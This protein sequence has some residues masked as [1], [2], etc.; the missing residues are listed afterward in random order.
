MNRRRTFWLKMVI[1]SCYSHLR[2]RDLGGKAFRVFTPLRAVGLSVEEG[3]KLSK[4]LGLASVTAEH[5]AQVRIS[6]ELLVKGVK[7]KDCELQLQ[8]RDASLSVTLLRAQRALLT[9]LKVNVWAVDQQDS[10]GG[11]TYDL[12]G[13]FGV[14]EQNWGVTGRVWVELKVYSEGTFEKWVAI[15][16]QK[17]AVDFSKKNRAD[18]TLQGVML[19]AASVPKASEGQW[20][21]PK[22][23]AMLKVSGAEEW[24]SLSGGSRRVARGQ[25]KGTKIALGKLWDKL[26]WHQG[27][28]GERVALLAQLLEELNLRA[29]HPGERAATL[30]VLLRQGNKKG[31]LVQT[32]LKL[33]SGKKPWVGTKDT[34]RDCYHYL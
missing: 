1:V 18:A 8:S 33:K 28:G 17:L 32:K 27:E 4:T 26:E 10:G 12:L 14:A 34:L 9:D 31:R 3:W 30:N 11:R 20:G 7:A 13:D 15:E 24:V 23:Q 21:I 16:K 29:D 25:A 2:K 6:G 5:L 19:L 22:L